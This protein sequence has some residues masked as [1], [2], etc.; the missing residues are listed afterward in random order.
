MSENHAP[1][2]VSV[3]LGDDS[4]TIYI[5]SGLLRQAAL[6]KPY[7]TSKQIC[8]VSNQVVADLYLSTLLDSLGQ[9]DK[10]LHIETVI[11]PEGEMNKNQAAL[12]LIHDRLIA[13]KFSRD[14]LI[15]AFGGGIVGDITGFAAA[16]YQRG[17]KFIQIPTTLLAQ[18]D[19]SVGGK[20]G[21]NH[22]L[23]KNLIG[24]FHQ[25]Q[26]VFIDTDVLNSLPAREISAGMAEV[27]KYGLIRDKAFLTRLDEIIDDVVALDADLMGEIIQ[28]SCQ[29]KADVVEADEK[30][31]GVRA[32]LNLGHTFGHAVESLTHY[33]SYL[34]GEAVAIG[35]MMAIDL[36]RDLGWLSDSDVQFAEQLF[37][38]AHCPTDLADC[39]VK[40]TP[41]EIR[42]TMQRDKKVRAG[43]LKL[44]L[45]QSLGNAVIRDD[46]DEQRVLK[47]IDGR[48]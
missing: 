42:E 15:I 16:S 32:T 18:V 33:K 44:I 13:Q 14:C 27:I 38:R 45:L 22:R 48:L 4:Y 37:K 23:G 36:S 31:H 19:S 39:E 35:T 47:A 1:R 26:T 9:I 41:S 40:L 2:T 46:I 10:D 25:P 6:I 43:Q 21:I 34:H 24:A 30:E 28:L 29:H 11:L 3:P 12:D 7:I 8:I 5:G 17:A 20:T